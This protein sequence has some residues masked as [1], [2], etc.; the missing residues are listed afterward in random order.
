MADLER[1]DTDPDPTFY[2]CCY[3]YLKHKK[4]L[5]LIMYSSKNFLCY[6]PSNKYRYLSDK[7][8]RH[9][10]LLKDEGR[11]VRDKGGGRRDKGVVVRS[12][13]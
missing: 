3:E 1:F 7:N 9:Y 11:G 5:N 13:R 4:H 10:F 12:E 8:H 2:L 6:F